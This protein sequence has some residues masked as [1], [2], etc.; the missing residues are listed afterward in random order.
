MERFRMLCVFKIKKIMKKNLI[1][2]IIIL[3]ILSLAT[4]KSAR[5]KRKRDHYN[6]HQFDHPDRNKKLLKHMEKDGDGNIF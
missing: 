3:L 4:C 6:K 5:L 2:F 1:Y